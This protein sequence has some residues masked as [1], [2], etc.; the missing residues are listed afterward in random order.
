MLRPG[1][2]G[3]SPSPVKLP[4]S[5]GVAL[6]LEGPGRGP[7]GADSDPTGPR[8]PPGPPQQLGRFVGGGR[9]AGR[10]WPGP[11]HSEARAGGGGPAATPEL[12]HWPAAGLSLP[13]AAGAE[14]VASLACCIAAAMAGCRDI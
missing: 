13:P 5:R 1:V 11:R 8:G 2:G 12:S 4:S 7:M 9:G 3:P 10:G 14:S 6:E